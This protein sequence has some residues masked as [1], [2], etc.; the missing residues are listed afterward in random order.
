MDNYSRHLF[1]YVD[2]NRLITWSCGHI[3]PPE[4]LIVLPVA[5]GSGEVDFDFTYQKRHMPTVVDALGH[6]IIGLCATIPDGVVIFFPSYRYLDDVVLR[7]KKALQAYESIWDLVTKRK[8][9]FMESRDNSNVEDV[10]QEYTNSID[11]GKGGLLLSV[12]GGKMSEGINFSDRLGRGVIV[13]GLPFPNIQS[14]QWKAKMGYIEDSTVGKGGTR[15]EGKA[16]AQDFYENACMRAVNQ[17]IGRAIRHQKDYASIVLLDRRYRTPKIEGKL[18]GWIKQ[19]LV[20]S[21][22]ERSFER[23]LAELG[24]FFKSKKGLEGRRE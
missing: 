19:G 13:V 2:A 5:K 12:I 17:S 21:K 18:P 20:A 10:L 15:D 23:V 6:A 8:P 22:D 16:A 14:A 9:T 1:P 24:N 4:N 11:A 3:I 7:W